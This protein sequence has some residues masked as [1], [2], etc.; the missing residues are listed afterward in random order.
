[1]SAG[2]LLG[3]MRPVSRWH[4]WWSGLFHKPLPVPAQPRNQRFLLLSRLFTLTPGG[5]SRRQPR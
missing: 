2:S 1:V 3:C 4:G 5:G